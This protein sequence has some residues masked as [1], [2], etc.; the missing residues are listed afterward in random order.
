MRAS[1]GDLVSDVVEALR[2]GDVVVIP[3]DTVY[4][5]AVDPTVPGATQRLFECKGRGRDV[6]IAV[7]VADADQAWSLAELPIPDTALDLAATHWPGALTIVVRRAPGWA[8]D[9]GDVTATIAVRCPDD[10]Q[11]RAWCR[12]VG[13]LAT[14]SANRHGEPT[15]VAFEDAARLG[16]VAVD[17]GR[18]SGAPSTVVDCTV[19]PPRVLR[20]GAIN[21]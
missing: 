10:E 14:S 19:D 5:V 4:G 1:V 6:P 18:L 17:G 3:T 11:V 9:L 13:P 16:T 2:R 21:L 7:L 20:Q 12:A 15:P 8:A